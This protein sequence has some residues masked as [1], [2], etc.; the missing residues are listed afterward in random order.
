[1]DASPNVSPNA[2]GPRKILILAVV[3]S[4]TSC[5]NAVR[6]VSVEEIVRGADGLLQ[7][8]K[9]EVSGYLNPPANDL[10]CATPGGSQPDEASQCVHIIDWSEGQD[11]E[12]QDIVTLQA[13]LQSVSTGAS[14]IGLSEVQLVP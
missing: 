12:G 9:V 7:G 4:L 2:Y 14:Q 10:L 8:D 6:S 13:Q 3:I 1:M 5:G 11:Q